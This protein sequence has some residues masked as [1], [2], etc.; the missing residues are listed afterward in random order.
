VG[1]VKGTESRKGMD[2]GERRGSTAFGGAGR[3]HRAMVSLPASEC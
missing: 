1:G 3:A 2:Y